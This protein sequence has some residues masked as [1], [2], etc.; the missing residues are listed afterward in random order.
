MAIG[1]VQSPG[2]TLRMGRKSR[3]LILAGGRDISTQ[4][5]WFAVNLGNQLV[6]LAKYA[7]DPPF[8]ICLIMALQAKKK[9][10]F[11]QSNCNKSPAD[12]P[13]GNLR[14]VTF[15]SV[16]FESSWCS[17]SPISFIELE[18]YEGTA[19]SLRR[20]VSTRRR[21]E[22]LTMSIID[23]FG[24][25]VNIT[26]TPLGV[27]LLFADKGSQTQAVHSLVPYEAVL[28]LPSHLLTL[29]Q[30]PLSQFC[31]RVWSQNKDTHGQTMR[32]RGLCPNFEPDRHSDQAIGAHT[33]YN[34]SVNLPTTGILRALGGTTAY[35]GYEINGNV[36]SL[37]RKRDNLAFFG[38][39]LQPYLRPRD[40]HSD[41][42]PC[43]YGL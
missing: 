26:G 36:K 2:D 32:D 37:G 4:W 3:L 20:L 40:P 8:S 7:G 1:L 24:N 19:R 5:D 30:T 43:L 17:L 21:T 29:L 12:Y 9:R 35:L 33:A 22:N 18:L 25:P 28:N 27:Q 16:S 31:D 42:H 39:Q 10:C 15:L 11:Q 41:R 34:I 6:K 23:S 13:N 14:S 38:C